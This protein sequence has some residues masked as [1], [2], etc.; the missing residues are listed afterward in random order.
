MC[1]IKRV[2]TCSKC[3]ITNECNCKLPLDKLYK[4]TNTYI[5]LECNKCN[6]II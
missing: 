5:C 6:N 4:I 2:F 3:N 1:N